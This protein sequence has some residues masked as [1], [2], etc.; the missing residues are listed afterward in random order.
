MTVRIELEAMKFYA[1]HG[2][3]PQE[4]RVGNHLW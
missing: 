2:V 3:S 1:W 4:M